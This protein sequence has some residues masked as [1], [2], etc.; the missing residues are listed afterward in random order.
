MTSNLVWEY[1]L[2]ILMSC[3]NLG[4]I[5]V[6]D[7]HNN[8]FGDVICKPLMDDDNPTIDTDIANRNIV[9]ASNFW[10]DYY[11]ITWSA[12][13]RYLDLYSKGEPKRKLAQYPFPMPNKSNIGPTADQ[14]TALLFPPRMLIFLIIISRAKPV[15]PAQFRKSSFNSHTFLWRSINSWF[16]SRFQFGCHISKIR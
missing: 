10:S 9:I 12:A 8:G 1:N 16:G 2:S 4:T 13:V 14:I 11:T 15:Y 5:I 7:L 3:Q 6:L